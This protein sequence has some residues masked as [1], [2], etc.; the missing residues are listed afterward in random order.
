ML[1]QVSRIPRTLSGMAA[2]M[3]DIPD[4]VRGVAAEKRYSQERLASV[5][6]IARS[7]VANRFSGR[8][9]FTGPELQRL[10]AEF[11]VPITRFFPSADAA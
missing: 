7:S 4:M 1:L 9:P 3:T 5:L 10:A 6:G 8:V 11:D 2:T